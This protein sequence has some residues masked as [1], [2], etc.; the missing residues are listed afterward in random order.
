M[1]ERRAGHSKLVAKEGKIV[2]ESTV[3]IAGP[4]PIIVLCKRA[5]I[6]PGFST[7]I[8]LTSELRVGC[9]NDWPACWSIRRSWWLWPREF[10]PIL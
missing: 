6:W 1:T 3:P 8:S 9:A 10:L 4:E 7:N 2:S 5:A